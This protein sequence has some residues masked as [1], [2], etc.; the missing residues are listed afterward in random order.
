M[1]AAIFACCG[2][3]EVP[4]FTIPK[5]RVEGV[6]DGDTFRLFLLVAIFDGA[7]DFL[8]SFPATRL[9]RFPV[10]FPEQCAGNP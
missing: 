8:G 9:G 2:V 10:G 5:E 1:E 6:R 3:A 7:F 4:T